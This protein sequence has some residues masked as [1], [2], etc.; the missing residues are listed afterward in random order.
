MTAVAA[1][2]LI[3]SQAAVIHAGTIAFKDKLGRKI[4]VS[5]PVRRVILFETYELTA[6]LDVWDK[7]AGISRYAYENDLMLALKPDIAKTIP[8]AGSA[9]DF[10][11]ETLLKSR[12]DLILTWSFKPESIRFMEAKGLKV[13]T[14]YPENLDELYETMRL[15]GR[16]FGKEK[17][18]ELCIARMK[19]IFAFIDE[20]CRRIPP[21]KRKKVIWLGSKQTTVWGA[22]GI[23]ND[24]ITL[25]GGVNPASSLMERSLDVSMERIMAWNPDVIF[26]W[27]NAKY[28]CADLLES[29]Q[30]RHMAAIRQS[31]VYKA[32]KWGVWSPRLAIVALWMAMKTY[33]D[34]F[35]D[36]NFT[37]TADE[38]YRAVYGISYG[39]VNRIA[40]RR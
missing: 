3:I 25:T 16:L 36:V 31:R 29:P 13:I 4:N 10:N 24:L 20:R 14:L 26:I 17:K 23:S 28:G 37:K 2:I 21:N 33:P 11:I 38:F 1:V 7:I 9:F 27:G 32:P 19:K 12:P 40:D 6:A 15:Q 30:W 35:R 22:H 39:S 5:L 34:R 18:V 8:S